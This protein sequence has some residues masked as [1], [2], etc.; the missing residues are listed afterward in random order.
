LV[1]VLVVNIVF[2]AIMF[3]IE[4]SVVGSDYGDFDSIPRAMWWAIVTM[5][6][7]GYGDHVPQTVGG[8]LVGSLCA[9]SGILIIAL[10][11]SSL[12]GL[13]QTT[14]FEDAIQSHAGWCCGLKPSNT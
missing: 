10:Y 12:L 6:T 9:L 3:S 1:F 2:A 7:V 4:S 8:Q 13:N 14:A 5:T 11:G